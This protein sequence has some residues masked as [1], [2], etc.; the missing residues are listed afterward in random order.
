MSWSREVREALTQAAGEDG[1]EQHAVQEVDG[2]AL[3]WTLRP[4]DGAALARSLAALGRH[5]AGALVR[6]GG[7]RLG[8]G[9]PPRRADLF[10]STERI[11]G[12]DEFD[13]GEGVCHVAA[14]TRLRELRERVAGGGW[15]LPFDPPGEG[16]TLGGTLASAALGPRALGFGPPR[17]SVLGLEVVLATGERTRCGGRVVKNVTG[18][19]LNKLYT[20]SLGTLG[21][22]EAAWLRLRP[23]AR[24][25]RVLAAE[26]AQ[27]CAVGLAAARRPS[28]RAA[29][30]LAADRPGGRLLVE[31]AGDEPGVDRDAEWFS[32][33]HGAR[34]VD[35]AE[36]GSA[37]SQQGETPSGGARFRISALASRLDAAL[38]ALRD[39]GAR[40]LVYPGLGLLYAGFALAPEEAGAAERAFD[41]ATR[42]ARA[43]GGAWLLEEA[44]VSAKRARDVF[45]GEAEL[46]PLVRAL[47]ARFDPA[48]VLNPG[49]FMGSV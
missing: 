38:A 25:V 6:G 12:V 26:P 22:I 48:D 45:G 23:L 30:L 17:D 20:G 15:E 1:L 31:F 8:L 46:L 41:A 9:N 11:V 49:R 18:Y 40:V 7:S 16:A 44:P 14:G 39:A 47:K 37:R 19:D 3:E 13:P 33:A 34:E 2:V 28:A 29:A 35:E 42:A 43:G 21:V 5:G 10:L 36:L 4:A 32:D 24:R 27:G